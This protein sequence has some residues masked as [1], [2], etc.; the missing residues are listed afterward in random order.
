VGPE[1][2]ILALPAN[3][4][5]KTR[6][7]AV[8]DQRPPRVPVRVLLVTGTADQ[9]LAARGATLLQ[10]ARRYPRGHLFVVRPD[11]YPGAGPTPLDD[12]RVGPL[13]DACTGNATS[14]GAVAAA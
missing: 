8:L 6:F 1:T 4:I 12:A 10:V 2:L 11:G 3:D 14:A 5:Q 7:L 13:V 9:D